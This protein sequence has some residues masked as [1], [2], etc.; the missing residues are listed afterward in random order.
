M[1]W[2]GGGEEGGIEG[3]AV[4]QGKGADDAAVAVAA[5]AGEGEFGAPGAGEKLSGEGAGALAFRGY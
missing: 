4:G 5:V 1:W 3:G 2:R